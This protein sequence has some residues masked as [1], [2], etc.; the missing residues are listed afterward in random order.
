MSSVSPFRESLKMRV[1][2]GDP[3]NNCVKFCVSCGPSKFAVGLILCKN[4]HFAFEACNQ[5]QQCSD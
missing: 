3:Q 4:N 5:A 1:V 2:L